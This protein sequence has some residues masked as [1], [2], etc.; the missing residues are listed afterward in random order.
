MES[1]LAFNEDY[2]GALDPGVMLYASRS[3]SAYAAAKPA[4]V[5]PGRRFAYSSGDTNLLMAAARSRSGLDARAWAD[6]P[7]DRLF[8]PVGMRSAV[9]E[10]DA[11]GDFVGSTFL[12]ASGVDW[13]R[14][15]LLLARDGL[16]EDRRILPEGWV[17]F[18]STASPRSG[19]RYGAHTWLRGTGPDDAGR[20]APVIELSGYGGQYVTVHPETETVVVRL[21]W[22]LDRSA[23][24]QT[25]FLREVFAALDVEATL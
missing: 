9:F 4:E 16:W 21:G 6:F 25:A 5:P 10:Q 24:N 14:F 13:A 18:M 19:G 23:W 7:R 11:G 3:A 22:T 20:R 1:G 2:A 17:E 12:Y 15:G 8:S